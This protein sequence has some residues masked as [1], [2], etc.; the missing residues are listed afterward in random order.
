ME[1]LV[2]GFH[3]VQ[4]NRLQ[5]VVGFAG[6]LHGIASSAI[7]TCLKFDDGFVGQYFCSL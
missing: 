6:D 5:L 7:G 2:T 4:I 3:G 1:Q